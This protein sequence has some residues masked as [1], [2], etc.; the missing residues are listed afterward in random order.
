MG[1]QTVAQNLLGRLLIFMNCLTPAPLERGSVSQNPPS[2]ACIPYASLKCGGLT[3]PIPFPC[4]RLH[5]PL[6]GVLSLQLVPSHDESRGDGAGGGDQGSSP[7][8][9]LS[10][11][12]DGTVRSWQMDMSSGALSR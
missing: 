1:P 6:T 2:A 12:R 11:G 3:Y 4:I 9:L 8:F 5:E 7:R 10:A